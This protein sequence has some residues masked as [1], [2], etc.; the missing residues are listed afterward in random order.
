MGHCV[1]LILPNRDE[2]AQA[3]ILDR[4]VSRWD[5]ATVTRGFGLWNGPKGRIRESILV[6]ECSI[7]VWNEDSE[8]WWDATSRVACI[9]FGE[10]CVFLSVRSENA[11]LVYP[12]YMEPI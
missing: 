8:V 4:I 3:E 10:T 6:L 5:G 9:L 2:G 11:M 1:R 7:P 12:D